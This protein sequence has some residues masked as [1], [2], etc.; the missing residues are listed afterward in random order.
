MIYK[1][2]YVIHYWT[3]NDEFVEEEMSSEEF[4]HFKEFVSKLRC[5]EYEILSATPV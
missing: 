5:G 2:S 4:E 3:K 1:V